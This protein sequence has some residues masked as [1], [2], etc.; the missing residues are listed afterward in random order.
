MEIVQVDGSIE[1]V[2]AGMEREEGTIRRRG[3]ENCSWTPGLG[4]EGGI[5]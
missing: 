3:V 2:P 4:S 5:G 1:L